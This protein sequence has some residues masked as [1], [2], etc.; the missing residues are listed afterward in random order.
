MISLIPGTGRAIWP[1]PGSHLLH[2]G[3]L[4]VAHS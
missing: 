1:V 2:V 3:A 4:S